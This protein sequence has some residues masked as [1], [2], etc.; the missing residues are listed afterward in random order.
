MNNSVCW[1]REGGGILLPGSAARPN[2][3]TLAISGMSPATMLVKISGNQIPLG[4]G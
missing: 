4:L 2:L 1:K 3:L